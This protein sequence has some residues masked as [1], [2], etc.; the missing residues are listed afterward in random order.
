MNTCPDIRDLLLEAT[1][2]ELRGEG[3]G[4]LPAHLRSC[5]ACRRDAALLLRADD[6]LEATLGEGGTPDVEAILEL[7][8]RPSVGE[9]L[10]R[11]ARA[12]TWATVV[13]RWRWV[14]LAAAA[15]VAGV[16]LVAREG[17]PP[18]LAPVAR[19][20]VPPTVEAA[21]TGGVAILETD[22]PDITV[23]WFFEQGT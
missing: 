10:P 1:P 21:S 15:A 17:G 7:A 4:A 13:G 6:A 18:P 20:E 12:R 3:E 8:A 5:E 14:G 11:R 22:N 9:A 23:L 19:S 2:A 16:L